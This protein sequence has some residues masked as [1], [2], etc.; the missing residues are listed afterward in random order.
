L[1]DDVADA[2][3]DVPLIESVED[4]IDGGE[5]IGG[6]SAADAARALLQVARHA[7]GLPRYSRA[8]GLEA[9]RIAV[10]RS[11]IE[12]SERDWR[13]KDPAW[14]SHP[15]YRR[16]MQA[17]LAWAATASDIVRDAD[18]DWRDRYRAELMV[19]VLTAAAAP[20]N[21]VVGNPA[22]LKRA[23][24]TAGASL[25]RGAGH[26]VRDLRHNRG[27]PSTV[28]RTGFEVGG[29]L[30]ATP[31]AV[32]YRDDVCEVLQY[33]PATPL[34]RKRPLLLIP[35]QIGKYYFMDLAPGRSFVEHAVARG[36]SF[37]LISW[38]NPTNEHASWGIDTYAAAVDRAIDVVRDV[39]ANDDVNVLG[40]CAGGILTAAM[41]GHLATQGDGRVRTAT[42]GVTLLDFGVP[43]QVGMFRAGPLLALGRERSSRAG[44]LDAKT[45]SAIFALL[46][47]NDLIFNYV[48]NNYLM[49][50]SPPRFDILAWNADGTNL[51]AQLH[52]QLLD[53]YQHNLLVEPDAFEVLGTPVDLR[54]V[55]VE[56]YVTGAT[57]DHLTPWKGCY[58]TTQLMSGPS[59]FILSNAG[60][61]ASLVNPP[62]NPKSHY[63]AGA[64]PDG[65]APEAWLALAEKRQGTWWTHWAE[66][67]TARS[68]EEGKA[69]SRLGSRRHKPLGLAPGT[70]VHG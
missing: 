50:E 61:I 63:F 45:L 26:L 14:Q 9:A 16:L 17:Y 57:T 23:F 20:T 43:A 3:T 54:R 30:A 36:I 38:R 2:D 32:V 29:N 5:A 40:L 31:G 60:H 22:A 12:A 44:V 41:L 1:R 58:R 4:A 15:G 69:P 33:A 70:Y 67:I 28:N 37:F 21:T 55:E 53:I 25:A 19:D 49:G 34:V 66:W 46:R 8:L 10:G 62:G 42:F 7:R 18:L 68:G 64:E 56:T 24:D 11:E 59:T 35:P 52:R 65:H 47:P 6:I 27:M 13:F 48:V 51:P 39:A